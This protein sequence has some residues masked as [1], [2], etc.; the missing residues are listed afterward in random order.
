MG[1]GSGGTLN[2]NFFI[3]RYKFPTILFK[4]SETVFYLV[5]VYSRYLKIL[6][7]IFFSQHFVVGHFSVSI[8]IGLG[9]SN[10]FTFHIVLAIVSHNVYQQMGS[11]FEDF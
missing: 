5:I 1:N 7:N 4:I 3:Q 8:H 11:D 9:S 2:R 10:T 6:E